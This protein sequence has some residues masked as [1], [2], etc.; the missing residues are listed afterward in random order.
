MPLP[1]CIGHHKCSRYL[2]NEKDEDLQSQEGSQVCIGDIVQG[3]AMI[4]QSLWRKQ[5]LKVHEADRW[6]FNTKYFG[7][8]ESEILM[9]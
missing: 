6:K 7:I 5:S 4:A 9:M 2:L 1:T 8:Y 3:Q